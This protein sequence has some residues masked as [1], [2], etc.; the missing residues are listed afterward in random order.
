MYNSGDRNLMKAFE[1]LN[2]LKEKLGLS[3]TIVEDAAYISRKIQE[4][5]LIKGRTADAMLAAA[6]YGACKKVE[7][8][9]TI[10]DIATIS[11]IKRSI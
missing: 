9:R 2:R 1:Q 7:T 6:M 5:G 8:P 11:N 3:D 4:R 10:K